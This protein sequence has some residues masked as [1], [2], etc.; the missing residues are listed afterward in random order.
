MTA[1]DFMNWR[2][3]L[4]GNYRKGVRAMEQIA[5]DGGM[6]AEFAASPEA[7]AV[8]FAFDPA[9][10]DPNALELYGILEK[11]GMADEAAMTCLGKYIEFDTWEEASP[12][13]GCLVGNRE[14]MAAIAASDLA[15]RAAVADAGFV[16]ALASNGSAWGNMMLLPERL[17][18][19]VAGADEAVL[20][21][22]LCEVSGI[23]GSPTL[24][25]FSEQFG[26][27]SPD[28]GTIAKVSRL[29]G[30][31]DEAAHPEAKAIVGAAF[32]KS[33]SAV[34]GGDPALMD[35]LKNEA[36]VSASLRSKMVGCGGDVDLGTYGEHRFLVVAVF[37]DAPNVVTMGC[38]DIVASTY[39]DKSTIKGW[40]GCYMRSWLTSNLLPELPANL[41]NAIKTVE[42]V[43]DGLLGVSPTHDF[44][45]LP[46]VYELGCLE[47][48]DAY[49]LFDSNESRIR[50]GHRY[51]TRTVGDPP[52][53]QSAGTYYYIDLDGTCG[54]RYSASNNAGVVPF[55]C[56]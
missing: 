56:I 39:M 8:V 54:K 46:S 44:L 40:S 42:K 12:K 7:V 49:P 21:A 5:M 55:F 24:S 28:G 10:P 14:A 3:L 16:S 30:L 52:A 25:V 2:A 9:D 13:M 23:S 31:I 43:N 20:V 29:A 35:A 6:L 27:M 33:F 41:R 37:R 34:L 48:D 36:R 53:G 19:G 17:A 26:A 15:T 1:T 47:S 38:A 51:Y 50:G 45:W 11:S 22:A 32:E 4:K 18:D